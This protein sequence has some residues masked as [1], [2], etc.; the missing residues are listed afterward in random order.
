MKN[1]NKDLKDLWI[2]KILICISNFFD[3]S[4]IHFSRDKNI[5]RKYGMYFFI[6][7][8]YILI[9]TPLI[10]L[11]IYFYLST[12]SN[13]YTNPA[14][15]EIGYLLILVSLC[16]IFLLIFILNLLNPQYSLPK[17]IKRISVI[18]S[19]IINKA[20]IIKI[21]IIGSLFSFVCYYLFKVIDK[22]LKLFQP[23]S[24]EFS[25]LI[26]LT[27]LLVV[28]TLITEATSDK[29][30]QSIR[31]FM[32]WFT[33]F[34][35]LLALTIKQLEQHLNTQK[36]D[37]IVIMSLTFSLLF[38]F[39]LILD[40]G[41]E[42]YLESLNTKIVQDKLHYIEENYWSYTHFNNKISE[43][44]NEF[45]EFINVWV[46]IFH[47]NRGV[48]YKS[49]FLFFG[50]SLLCILIFIVIRKTSDIFMLYLN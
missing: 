49:L 23:L 46:T 7:I 44:R 27:I 35:C 2:F 38:S 29:L 45:V 13:E 47:S 37:G 4:L 31:K 41:R 21:L 3:T 5:F 16:L 39:A 11:F 30:S 14:F 25:L 36:L 22:L 19:T 26:Q 12:F 10:A 24:N 8:I 20:S 50:I 15:Y 6:H 42:A 33:L 34:I 32:L 28:I 48:F 9:F 18:L 40:K 17:V 43:L 1:S